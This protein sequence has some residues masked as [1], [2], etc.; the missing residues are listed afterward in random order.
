MS[1]RDA[2]DSNALAVQVFSELGKSLETLQGAE[3]R[4]PFAQRARFVVRLNELRVIN[5]V[6]WAVNELRLGLYDSAEKKLET[7]RSQAHTHGLEDIAAECDVR[8]AEVVSLKGDPGLALKLLVPAHAALEACTHHWGLATMHLLQA[9][10]YATQGA[11]GPA[12]DAAQHA[13]TAAMKANANHIALRI[14]LEIADIAER[15]D[16]PALQIKALK[17]AIK[18]HTILGAGSRNQTLRTLRELAM[19]RNEASAT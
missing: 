7:A 3:R 12:L 8:L 14:E 19:V 9:H 2:L 4:L 13:K 17:A 18:L 15:S 16:N 6:N 11:F 1:C 10:C 5:T